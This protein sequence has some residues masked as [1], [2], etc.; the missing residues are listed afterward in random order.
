MKLP[1]S[2]IRK[3]LRNFWLL[4]Y[5][6]SHSNDLFLI[7]PDS[8][9]SKARLLDIAMRDPRQK[10]IL[11]PINLN[12]PILIIRQGKPLITPI[13]RTDCVGMP[14]ARWSRIQTYLSLDVSYWAEFEGGYVAGEVMCVCTRG[15]E[16]IFLAVREEDDI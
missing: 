5:S 11:P 12:P 2:E 13:A 10:L 7:I 9:H 8:I 3:S 14:T 4:M 6:Y 1:L 16:E 15:G